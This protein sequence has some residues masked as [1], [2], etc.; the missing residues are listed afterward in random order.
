MSARKRRGGGVAPPP[1]MLENLLSVG[2]NQGTDQNVAGF[3]LVRV[4]RARVDGQERPSRLGSIDV[5]RARDRREGR[6]KRNCRVVYEQDDL[7]RS[8]HSAR[9]SVFP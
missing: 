2:R 6:A 8:L 5:A 1:R 9:G 4:L 7:P 3:D